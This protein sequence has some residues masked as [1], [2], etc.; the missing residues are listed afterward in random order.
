MGYISYF[1]Y[2]R[3]NKLTGAARNASWFNNYFFHRYTIRST[4][5]QHTRF[6]YTKNILS[7]KPIIRI[8][9]MDTKKAIFVVL[10][11]IDGAGK[12]TLAHQLT[13]LLT[14][15][16]IRVILT[17]EPGGTTTG[18]ALRTLL[19]QQTTPLDTKAEFLL[20]A[21]DR[22]Q[23]I[24]EI[25]ARHWQEHCIIIS[26]RFTDS[27]LVYQGHG[28]GLDMNMI[29]CINNWILDTI[30]PDITFY[31]KIPYSVA[32]ARITGS[33][34]QLSSFEQESI[35]F[36]ERIITGFDTLYY[37]RA[38]VVTIN[39]DEDIKTVARTAYKSLM[40]LIEKTWHT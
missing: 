10:E 13:S 7:C 35:A 30:K 38:D 29:N 12:S 40:H 2:F 25:I 26:D 22:A 39:A 11:G 36:T 19:N 32:R 9:T 21:A 6:L 31:L 14:A 1:K 17:R 37:Q 23:H 27:S 15:Q 3:R 18:K 16:G 24:N 20:F 8:L 5:Y 28:R 4:I 34:T 33:R